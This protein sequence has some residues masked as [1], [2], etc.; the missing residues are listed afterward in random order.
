MK[1][2]SIFILS[3]LVVALMSSKQNDNERITKLENELFEMKKVFNKDLLNIIDFNR[4]NNKISRDNFCKIH[5]EDSKKYD[6]RVDTE[7]FIKE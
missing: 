2:L 7:C 4:M 1:N 5:L 6:L 3:F